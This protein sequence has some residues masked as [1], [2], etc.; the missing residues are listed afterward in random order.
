MVAPSISVIITA[1]NEG[2]ELERTVRSVVDRT[3]NLAEVIVVDE[4]SQDGSCQNL[5]PL[6]ARVIR[7]DQ[8][9]GVAVSRDEGSRAATGD[10]LCYLDG[11]QRLSKHCLDRCAQLAIDRTAITCPDVQDYGWFAWRLY[12]A[13]FQLCPKHGY[14]SGDWHEWRPWQRVRS[15]S[16]LRAPPY[17]IPRA[18]YPSV[19][20]S[21]ALRGWGAS[22]ASVVV[23]SFFTGVNILHLSGPVARH[24]FQ[25]DFPYETTWG[26]IWRNQAIIAR[27]CF[28]D[29]TWFDYWLP[30]V[31]DGHLGDETSTALESADLQ[32][33]HRAFLSKKVRTDRQFWTD[34]VGGAPPGEIPS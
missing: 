34:L 6:G 7:H 22:E 3:R 31:F 18:L 15:V 26:G 25:N 28:D 17:L 27:V 14:F 21:R 20:W 4:G 13:K 5:S 16:G 12:G 2:R 33:E 29:A 32:A 19:A 9:V 23:K 10:V 11:H 1:H 24:R 8:R 30:K